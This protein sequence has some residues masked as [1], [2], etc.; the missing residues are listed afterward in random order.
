MYKATEERHFDFHLYRKS[1]LC[2]VQYACVCKATG[3]EI[4]FKDL[5]RG[6]EYQK[7]D[8]VVLLDKDFNWA[9]SKR[10]ETIEIMEFVNS[11]EI[12]SKYF[13]KPGTSGSTERGKRYFNA[14]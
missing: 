7:G 4:A 12:N 8:I 14:K 1:D 6:Y 10:T 9:Y 2:P 11:N 5:V 13:E 3:E